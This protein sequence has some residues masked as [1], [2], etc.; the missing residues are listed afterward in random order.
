M[1]SLAR[2]RHS[3]TS[4]R[5]SRGPTPLPT[6]QP[7][8]HRLNE[9][10]QRALQNL[11]RDHRLDGLKQKLK[12]AN[13]HLTTAAADINDRLQLQNAHYEKLKKRLEK[14]GSQESNDEQD[15][16]IAEARAETNKMTGR[17]E[18]G[19]R[20]II[21]AS[22]EVEGV[23][24]ALGQLQEHVSE[25]RGRVTATQSSLGAS[26]NRPARHGRRHGVDSE[27]EGSDDEEGSTQVAGEDESVIGALKRKVADQKSAYQAMSMARRYVRK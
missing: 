24:K 6:Y 1:A 4:S 15:T 27:D 17:L 20:K 25:G 14:Q 8:Q 7:L 9:S 12:L 21:D 2:S 19:M 22:A 23:E 13:N 16:M 10:A 11:P 3:T 18:E 5:Q 26:Y